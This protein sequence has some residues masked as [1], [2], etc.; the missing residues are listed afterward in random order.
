MF[1]IA[2]VLTFQLEKYLV[3]LTNMCC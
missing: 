1:F 2:V 3:I